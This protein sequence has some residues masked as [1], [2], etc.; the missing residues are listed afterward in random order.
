MSFVVNI[1]NVFLVQLP[2]FSFC[3]YSFGCNYYLFAIIIIIIIIN[4]T[5]VNVGGQC[6]LVL[7]LKKVQYKAERCEVKR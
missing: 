7:L 3:H 6:P 2:N 1:S 4:V 5:A